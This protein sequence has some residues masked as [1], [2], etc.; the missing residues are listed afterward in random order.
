M[1]RVVKW[2]RGEKGGKTYRVGSQVISHI[3]PIIIPDQNRHII[4]NSNII[5]KHVHISVVPVYLSVY[6]ELQ[7]L[8]AYQ[9]AQ[10]HDTISSIPAH[11]PNES[12]KD[13]HLPPYYLGRGSNHGPNL[14]SFHFQFRRIGG[15]PFRI[16]IGVLR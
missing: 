16:L 1:G 9:H 10:H 6:K 3:G 12:R 8:K 2:K 11:P 14:I 4:F 13:H 5:R 15:L 7:E